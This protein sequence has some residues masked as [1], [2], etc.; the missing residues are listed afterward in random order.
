MAKTQ[1]IPEITFEEL[2]SPQAHPAAEERLMRIRECGTVVVRG[3]VSEDQVS[4][5][6]LR[7]SIGTEV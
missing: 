1:C 4:A 5:A 6:A 3:V 2:V 7:S